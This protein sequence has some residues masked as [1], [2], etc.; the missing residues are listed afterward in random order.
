MGAKA[1][2]YYRYIGTEVVQSRCRSS[3]QEQRCTRGSE[4]QRCR[5]GAEVHDT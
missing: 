1:L 2:R 4:V 3:E 5:R